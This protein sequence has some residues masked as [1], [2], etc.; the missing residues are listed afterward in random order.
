MLCTDWGIA[1]QQFMLHPSYLGGL[2]TV[3][4][5]ALCIHVFVMGKQHNS[6]ERRELR[7]LAQVN[8]ASFKYTA[9]NYRVR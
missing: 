7:I 3:L 6:Q 8:I 9:N 2:I 5:V 1:F 4:Y